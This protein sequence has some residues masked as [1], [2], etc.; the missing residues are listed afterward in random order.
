MYRSFAAAFRGHR[1]LV[2]GMTIKRT[3]ADY[4]KWSKERLIERIRELEVKDG[5]DRKRREISGVDG[6]MDGKAGISI[7]GNAVVAHE[8][9]QMPPKK[10]RKTI[11][12]SKYQSRLIALKF[13]YLGWDYQGLAV[14]G[15]PTERPTVEEKIIKALV[16]VRL[17]KSSDPTQFQFSRCGRTD[18]GVSAMNQVIT[19]Q[20]RSKLS[21]EELQDPANDSKELDYIKMLNH[22]LPSDIRFHAICLRPPEGFDAR[23]SCIWRQYKYIF[24]GEGVDIER[25][26]EAAEYFVG[27]HD[28][29]N[30]C[31]VDGS[32]QLTSFTREV[33]S[34]SI[35][36]LEEEPGFYVFNLKGSAF[37]WHQ[38]RCMMAVLLTVGQG[39]EK[40]EIVTGLMDI[41]RFP[42]RPAYKLA[43][44][45]PLILYDCGYD[46]KTV[47]WTAGPERQYVSHLGLNGMANDYKIKAVVMEYM[48]KVV[49]GS[50]P[51]KADKIV[52]HL[53]DGMGQISGR[54]IPYDEKQKLDAPEMA[55]KRWRDRKERRKVSKLSEESL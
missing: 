44:D 18:K 53:G 43:H 1:A 52:I 4:T 55:N 49:K 35:H 22:V 10:P 54:Y 7:D 36:E 6:V 5:G 31:K 47:K 25:M 45:I 14:Q 27:Q 19:L 15:L 17:V 33:F 11:D 50:L 42:G 8:H 2:E 16:Q 32:K 13:A 34:V 26:R 41:E 9:F 38:V 48:E 21:E 12:F 23:F 39:Y 37:L 29:R 3:M 28:F 40:P 46:E 51:E 20:V 24:N 30:F